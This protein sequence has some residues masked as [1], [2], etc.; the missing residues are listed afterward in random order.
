M[1]SFNANFIETKTPDGREYTPIFNSRIKEGVYVQ[2]FYG[3][4]IQSVRALPAVLCSTV[5]SYWGKESTAYPQLR[6]RSIAQ[7]L[8]EFEYKSRFYEA[9]SSL[10]FD[11]FGPFLQRL[12]FDEVHCM[13]PHFVRPDERQYVW[14]WGL[15]D[16]RFYTK[17]FTHL[18]DL[19]K[20]DQRDEGQSPIFTTLFTG[21]H[22]YPFTG[23]PKSERYLYSAPADRQQE[24]ANS[25]HL[26][27]R[28]LARFF[29]ELE[30]RDYLK[31]SLVI[32]CG[33][34]SF[35]AG[36][37]GNYYNEN[38]FY[39]ENFRTPLLVWWPSHLS[40]KRITETVCSQLDIAP[41]ILD[42]LHIS[43][44]NHFCGKSIFGA[45]QGA[46]RSIPLIQPYNGTY[47]CVIRYPY[48]YVE[49]L[50]T[51]ERYLFDL[52]HDPK[53]LRNVLAD[54]SDTKLLKELEEDVN[55]IRLNQQLIEQNRIWPQ[56]D[57]L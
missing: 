50:R 55:Y 53:E 13:D 1:E 26:A 57:A 47:L 43:A 41:T 20:S 38:G 9:Y 28:Y 34:H 2:R 40:Q 42:I 46:F 7:I 33:D 54:F 16:D 49:S 45:G 35:P 17:V 25:I 5:P 10:E 39:E 31:D 4:S 15:Q 29:Q 52:D 18:D 21:S 6:L 56:L 30:S 23:V 32:I 22:H 12:G 11:Q 19:R 24:F 44:S 51:S 14:G 27:D 37:H 3:N 48:K 8:R 36:E